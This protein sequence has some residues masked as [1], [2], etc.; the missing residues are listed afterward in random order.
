MV[1][2]SWGIFDRVSDYLYDL[3]SVARTCA[4]RCVRI[5]NQQARCAN[6]IRSLVLMLKRSIQFALPASDISN[7]SRRRVDDSVVA[8]GTS[9]S[10]HTSLPLAPLRPLPPPSEQWSE[11][12][13]RSQ[14]ADALIKDVLWCG[15]SASAAQRYALKALQDGMPPHSDLVLLSKLGSSGENPCH[16]WR[17]MK[18]KFVDCYVTKAMSRSRIPVKSADG[19]IQ[20]QDYNML[21]PHSLF[22]A[23]YHSNYDG[24]V[25]RV[26]GG[27]VG[28][29]KRF[30]DCQ[31]DHPNYV[32]HPILEDPWFCTKV[33]PIAIHGDDVPSI[34]VGKAWTKMVQCVSWS[35]LLARGSTNKINFI[36]SF[37]FLFMA[38]N[39][40]GRDTWGTYWR[41]VIWSLKSLQIGKWPTHDALG[42]RYTRGLNKER[43]GTWLADGHRAVLWVIRSDLDYIYQRL[44]GRNYNTNEE[45]CN[46]CGCN[47][48]N[49][50]HQNIT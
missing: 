9:S 46:L 42:V 22:A 16:C 21:C 30:W 23:L 37:M 19:G 34:S 28:N 48:T 24:F 29:I 27:D 40:G 20:V 14:L 25:R 4:H 8:A 11:T 45:P 13:G 2:V 39:A 36:I 35:S 5:F 38:V 43:A 41:H 50:P 18:A 7:R 17:D 3:K 31:K 12:H 49:R 33:V 44:G 10:S 1:F 15:L 47:G 6:S 32:G 26:L